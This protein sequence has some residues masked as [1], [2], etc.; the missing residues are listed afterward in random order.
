MAKPLKY[1]KTLYI[2]VTEEL[3]DKINKRA[4]K[5]KIPPTIFVRN[6]LEDEMR[7]SKKNEKIIYKEVPI[8]IIKAFP[9]VK[10]P[11]IDQKSLDKEILKRWK[12]LEEAWLSIGKE[13]KKQ[14]KLQVEKFQKSTTTLEKLSKA[15][16]N[17]GNERRN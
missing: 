5:F 6:L 2:R 10:D 14:K 9:N 13:F 16:Q 8:E 3:S 4:E 15:I 12:Y 1:N 17:I 11:R 7:Q